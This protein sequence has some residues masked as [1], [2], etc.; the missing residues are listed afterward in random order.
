MGLCTWARVQ[1]TVHL[2]V[3][4]K[5]RKA[6]KWYSWA[7]WQPKEGAT[8]AS[9]LQASNFRQLVLGAPIPR[10]P[11]VG[12]LLLSTQTAT[13]DEPPTSEVA[14]ISVFAVEKKKR[15]LMFARAKS[16]SVPF[17]GPPTGRSCL[18]C[19]LGAAT[20]IRSSRIRKWLQGWSGSWRIRRQRWRV[21]G[22]QNWC[23]DAEPKGGSDEA[24]EEG[25]CCLATAHFP[26]IG[27]GSHTER[28][29]WWRVWGCRERSG[30]EG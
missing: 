14:Q 2:E 20:T 3:I 6:F 4:P 27:E 9:L 21:A 19:W 26:N 15:W 10:P 24:C 12:S 22:V 16:R 29:E 13:N 1:L 7:S 23:G 8:C 5:W 28:F 11:W 25:N 18:Q 30:G 17:L